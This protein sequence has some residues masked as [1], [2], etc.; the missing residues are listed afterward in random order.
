MTPDEARNVLNVREGA[1]RGEI[2][3]A[4]VLNRDHYML[5][6]RFDTCPQRRDRAHQALAL[7]NDAYRSLT[8]DQAPPQGAKNGMKRPE[9]GDHIPRASLSGRVAPPAPIKPDRRFNWLCILR[10]LSLRPNP[11]RVAASLIC[12]AMF[13][14]S[15]LL[16]ACMQR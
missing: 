7:L 6:A 14:I 11:E 1:A 12:F 3:T 15:L 2:D 10:D 16:L 9:S 8:G 4:F 5:Q 13:V